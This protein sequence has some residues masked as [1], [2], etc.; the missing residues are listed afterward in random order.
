MRGLFLLSVCS[1]AVVADDGFCLLR[2]PFCLIF[3]CFFSALSFYRDS[4]RPALC[5]DWPRKG[6]G[7]LFLANLLF[8]WINK[9]VE[10]TRKRKEGD[11]RRPR[12]VLMIDGPE[13]KVWSE[14][15]V[16]FLELPRL[17]SREFQVDQLFPVFLSPRLV[18][19]SNR[20]QFLHNMHI[21][22]VCDLPED[23]RSHSLS[24][25]P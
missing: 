8:S 12:K 3:F 20:P 5:V 22:P 1:L 14:V 10:G 4:S 11:G 7:K 15:V 16:W 18:W 21:H 6:G 17:F 23:V 13:E 25:S 24:K 2:W 19:S 9:V